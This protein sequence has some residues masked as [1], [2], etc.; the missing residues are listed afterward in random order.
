MQASF[1]NLQCLTIEK[2]GFDINKWFQNFDNLVLDLRKKMTIKQNEWTRI[3][4]FSIK[5]Q[6]TSSETRFLL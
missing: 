5:E 2:A 3:L 6:K 1:K 4:Q